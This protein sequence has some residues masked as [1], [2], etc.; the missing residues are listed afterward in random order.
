MKLHEWMYIYI[1][2]QLCMC[3][4]AHHFELPRHQQV[5]FINWNIWFMSL[6]MSTSHQCHCV[7]W[8]RLSS[9]YFPSVVVCLV[10]QTALLPALPVCASVFSEADY[11]PYCPSHLWQC[12]Q[13]SILPSILPFP[14]VPVCSVKQTVLHTALPL[15]VSVFSEADYPPYCPSHLWQCVQWSR[16]LSILP[17]P[18]VPVCSVKQTAPILPFPFVPVCS[19]KQTALHTALPICASVFSEADC[20]PYCPSHLC[21]CVQWS[22][23]LFILPFPSVPMCSVKQTTLWTALSI[24]ASVLS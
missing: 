2:M 21:Q 10:K 12:V 17:F 23:L 3:D 7:Q 4:N 18:F 8:S 14:F 15:C 5:H 22:R 9:L 13:W 1:Y 11:P 6:W 19:V 16:L 24:C 20:S